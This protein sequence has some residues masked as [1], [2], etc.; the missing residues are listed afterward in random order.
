MEHVASK[1]PKASLLQMLNQSQAWWYMPVILGGS[2][3]KASP[4]KKFKRPHL[5]QQAKYSDL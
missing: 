4:S 2:W 3:F 1:A 5:N